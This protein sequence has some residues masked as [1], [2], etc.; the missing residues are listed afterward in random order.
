MKSFSIVVAV[1]SEFGIGKVGTLPW[2]LPADMKHF[3]TVTTHNA[4]DNVVIMGRKTWDSIP[5]K[6]RPLS[7][8]LNI[9]ISR[10]EDLIL[11]QGVLLAQCL[12]HALDLLEED[13]R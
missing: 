13:P 8:R 3:K 11:P 4:S 9:V 7:Q 12:E 5:E 6:F 10:Q 2:H 1:D